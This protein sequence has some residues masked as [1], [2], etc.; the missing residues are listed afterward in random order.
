M[1]L[2]SL[3]G[4]MALL[5]ATTLAFPVPQDEAADLPPAPVEVGGTTITVPPAAQPT[6]YFTK[7]KT[8]RQGPFPGISSCGDSTFED[9]T[10]A[11]SPLIS[12]CLTM[13]SNLVR[14][15]ATDK[16]DTPVWM[17]ESFIKQQHQLVQ[18]GT[19]AFGV[20]GG[21]KGDL[22]FRVGN[23]DIIDIVRSAVEKFGRDGRVGARGEMRCNAA[24]F[25]PV[26]SWG[27]YKNT[28][29]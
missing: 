9:T 18:F 25:P 11:G 29:K 26:I 10:S 27:I 13:A 2:A 3:F 6:T 24:V 17:V 16:A 1:H 5:L 12:D 22:T 23:Q 28:K 15:E 19:C 20:Q 7:V 21:E 8:K 4:F 14:K